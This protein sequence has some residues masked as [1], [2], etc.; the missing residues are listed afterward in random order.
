[1]KKMS[2]S[3]TNDNNELEFLKNKKQDLVL[4]MNAGEK[5]LKSAEN[6]YEEKQ[7]EESMLRLKVSQMEKMMTN[8]GNNVYNLERYRLELEAV[9]FLRNAVCTNSK[10]INEIS[11]N[12]LKICINV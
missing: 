2:S 6:R 7:V 5:E 12:N 3:L 8:I 11:K 10:D 1:M 4:L 9:S